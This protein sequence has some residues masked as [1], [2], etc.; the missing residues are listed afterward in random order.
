[1]QRDPKLVEFLSEWPVERS[2]G[3]VK[4]VNGSD[5]ADELEALRCSAQ[6]GRP[7][8]GEVWVVRMVKRLGLESMLRPWGWPKQT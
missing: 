1:M 6:R 8:G 2:C 5:K 4:I 7:F 3:W